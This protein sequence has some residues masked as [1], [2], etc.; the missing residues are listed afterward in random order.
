VSRKKN[1][2]NTEYLQPFTQVPGTNSASEGGGVAEKTKC[3]RRNDFFSRL[4][5]REAH[6][7][8]LAP[9]GIGRKTPPDQ[10]EKGVGPV[11]A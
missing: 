7:S 5:L 8:S 11:A 2:G 1:V 3:E 4:S 6:Y 10:G 9:G